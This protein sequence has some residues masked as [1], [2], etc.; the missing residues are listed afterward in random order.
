LLPGLKRAILH[1]VLLGFLVVSTSNFT[2]ED[3]FYYLSR[4]FE[5]AII[6]PSSEIH[7]YDEWWYSLNEFFVMIIPIP[8]SK[9]RI[10]SF[11]P[12]RSRVERRFL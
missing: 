1:V 3:R 6:I 7:R 5:K 10:D 9:K 11:N 12:V 8:V 4:N 2:E